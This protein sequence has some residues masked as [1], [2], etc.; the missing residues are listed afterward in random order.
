MAL[1]VSQ[2]G[3]M[4]SGSVV[5]MLCNDVHH[6]GSVRRGSRRGC[7]QR[8]RLK[9][10]QQLTQFSGK[11]TH[12]HRAF[13][14][15]GPRRWNSLPLNIRWVQ[16]LEHFKSLLKTRVYGLALALYTL[17]FNSLCRCCF[18]CFYCISLS[19]LYFSCIIVVD[20]TYFSYI[21]LC[22]ALCATCWKCATVDPR[23]TK[24]L[25]ITA[26]H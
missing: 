25:G 2:S 19:V 20:F 24:G 16:T 5:L 18:S 10:T 22:K 14:V 15:A 3:Y 8:T 7:D 11:V 13:S 6:A 17:C 12:L 23:Y 21:L 4:S 1:C 26:T 9:D